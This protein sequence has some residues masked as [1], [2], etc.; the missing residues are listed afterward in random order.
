MQIAASG[1]TF[2]GDK[3]VLVRRLAAVGM[4]LEVPVVLLTGYY[5]YEYMLWLLEEVEVELQHGSSMVLVDRR[6]PCSCWI[7]LRAHLCP[8]RQRGRDLK[9][10]KTARND[11]VMLCQ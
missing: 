1:S 2:V 3:F 11:R 9:Y 10:G 4:A 7:A 6:A 8:R 5:G